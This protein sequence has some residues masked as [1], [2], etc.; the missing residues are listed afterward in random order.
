MGKKKKSYTPM[1]SIPEEM[2]ARY[3]VVLEVLAGQTSVSEGAR[4]LGLS[5]NHFQT[6]LHRGL[7]GL[8]EGLGPK[9]T[10]RPPMPRDEEKERLEKENARLRDRVDTIDRLMEVASGIL[11]DQV[12]L[13]GRSRE[14]RSRSRSRTPTKP[15]GDDDDDESHRL[16]AAEALRR[17]GLTVVLAAALVGTSRATLQRWRVR[18]QGGHRAARRRG[19]ASGPRPGSAEVQARAEAVVRATRG[20]IGAEALRQCVPDVSRR[21][22]AMIKQAT[23]SA[24]ERERKAACTRVTVTMPGVL[25]G[26]DQLFV[27]NRVALVSADGCVPFRTST[28]VVDR[29]NGPAVAEALERD[30]TDQG[31]PLVQRLDRARAHRVEDVLSLARHH[32]VLLLH[33][34][35]RYPQFYGQLERQNREHRAW[36][37]TLPDLD[38]D[39]LGP[40][41]AQM[42]EVL[43]DLLPRRTL[44]WRTAR[45][46]WVDRPAIPPAERLALREDVADRTERIARHLENRGQP[47]DFAE[48]L[49]IEQALSQRGLLRR[50]VG[51][52]C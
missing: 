47:A 35:P 19:P 48:R 5:R 34:P 12:K 49:A 51:G 11:K 15:G 40:A 46:A 3:Q 22:A 1:P 10:G 36:L 38:P 13:T 7:E 28:H 17:L 21:R 33:G 32:R 44:R 37:E 4:R 50:K 26:F 16:R 2:R 9:P 14:P 24:M 30:W 8:I 45:D 25:R 23:R 43:N 20:L 27:G 18:V 31:A 29:Y 6:L 42:C 52:W 41:C 39:A